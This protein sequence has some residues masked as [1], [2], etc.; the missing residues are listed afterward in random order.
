MKKKLLLIFSFSLTSLTALSS[1]QVSLTGDSTLSGRTGTSSF[2]SIGMSLFSEYQLLKSAPISIGMM[3]SFHSREG[4]TQN[5]FAP[6]AKFWIP[7]ET[8]GIPMLEPYLRAGYAFSWLINP[9]APSKEVTSNHGLKVTLGNSFSMT[10][11]FSALAAYTLNMRNHVNGNTKESSNSHSASIGF[12][13][14]M[15]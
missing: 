11:H 6:V 4:L 7:K 15:F 14:K 13:A 3:G 2:T 1:L 10:K 12:S 5:E 9:D 8:T